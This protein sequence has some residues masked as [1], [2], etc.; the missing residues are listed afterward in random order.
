MF[1][2]S[3]IIVFLVVYLVSSLIAGDFYKVPVTA[4]F[5]IAAIY[6]VIICKE[7]TIEKKVGVFSEGVSDKNVMMMVWIFILAGAFAST[8]KS[9]GSI[10]ATVNATLMIIPGKLI[11]AGLFLASCFVS[12]AIGTSVGTIVA[13]VPIAAGIAS[14][15]DISISMVTAIIVGGAFFGDNL[16]FISDTTIASTKSQGCNMS[17]KFKMNIR[18]ALPAAIIA[19][20]IY[21]MLGMQVESVPQIEDPQWILVLPYV[22]II[23]LALSGVNVMLVLLIGL[24]FNS[25][26]GLVL[27]SLSWVDLLSAIGS[28]ITGMMELIIV[29]LLASG[30][31]SVIRHNGGIDYLVRI[32]TKRISSRRAAEA[33]IAGLVC[34]SNLCTANNTIAIITAGGIA[35]DISTKFGI[36][37]RRTASLMDT[38]SCFVQSI[39]PYGAQLL[40]AS[41]LAG[42][43]A[44]S[45]AANLC[46]P[47][48]L[49]AI[50]TLTI[51]IGV[52][53]RSRS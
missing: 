36:D 35:K 3:P 42:V 17:D 33:T 7:D 52:P 30:V 23:G 39:I 18:L 48:L 21:V 26:L 16:S 8:A 14:E 37:P 5:L 6:A 51:I 38:F 46:Y 31:L 10:D 15:T 49:G 50:A 43:S 47:F 1:A 27:G 9:I 22:L 32:L 20:A 2:V 24:V 34:L 13:L 19:L 44:L 41:G 28:G 29:T 53:V 12:M 25:L 40:M 45:I 4:A 11:F